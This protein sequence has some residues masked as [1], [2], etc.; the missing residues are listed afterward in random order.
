MINIQD[1][2]QSKRVFKERQGI[3]PAL[4]EWHE[5]GAD[6]W[7][8]LWDGLFASEIFISWQRRD[9]RWI[10]RCVGTPGS[11]KT[12]LSALVTRKLKQKYAGTRDA[13]ASVFV[14]NDVTFNG[15]AFVEDVLIVLFNQLSLKG[16]EDEIIAA[17]Y[18]LY[19]DARKHGHRD[20]FRIQLTR[21]ALYSLL[22][23]LDH[24]FLIVDD[25]DRCSPAVDLFL[26]N[27]LSLLATKGLKVFLTSRITCLK[28]LPEKVL[29]DSCVTEDQE[30]LSVYWACAGCEG[31]GV[32]R[33]VVHVLCQNCREKGEAC[34]KCGSSVNFSQPFDHV[35]LNLG[36]NNHYFQQLIDRELE[37]EHGDLG[38][39]STKEEKPP[40]SDLGRSL[41]DPRNHEA[42]A[43]L[44]SRTADQADGNVSLA[45][46]RLNNVH[47]LQSVDSILSPLSDVL[48][49]NVVAFFDAGM[50][51][52]EEQPPYL[53]DLGLKVIAAVA[54]YGYHTGLGYEVLDKLIQNSLQTPARQQPTRTQSLPVAPTTAATEAMEELAVFHVPHRSLEEMLHAARG[55]LVMGTLG[56]RPLRAYCQAFYVYVKENYNE[57][58]VRA[59][60]KLDFD[61]VEVNQEGGLAELK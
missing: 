60:A 27:E 38:L 52:I 30:H 21:D 54:H 46:L 50:Q 33:E 17:K 26:E 56:Y 31:T 39:K 20:V 32:E 51:R 16:I 10:L 1:Q 25:F 4:S 61:S 55:F 57:S 22:T 48:P 59:R 37:M 12:T 53:R 2:K 47:Q 24:A 6:T 13:V 34:G 3:H 36:F 41:T 29:C 11:G 40:M 9:S 14:R 43:T 58:L 23:K 35:E 42:L 44:R 19:L 49:A 18:R 15:T 28:I 5:P 7:E 45:L 8:P